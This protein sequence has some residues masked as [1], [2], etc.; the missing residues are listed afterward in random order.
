[1]RKGVKNPKKEKEKEADSIKATFFSLLE[2][3][4]LWNLIIYGN[5]V[6]EM[7]GVMRLG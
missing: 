3:K 2:R 1:M 5:G 6:K 4:I 7:T